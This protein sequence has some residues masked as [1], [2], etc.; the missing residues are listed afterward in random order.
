MIAGSFGDILRVD[1][2]LYT[3]TFTSE[4]LRNVTENI[5]AIAIVISAIDVAVLDDKTICVIAQLC[6]EDASDEIQEKIVEKFLALKEK[7]LAKSS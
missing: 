6:Y 4:G 5:V 1:I 2:Q 7:V 3:Y